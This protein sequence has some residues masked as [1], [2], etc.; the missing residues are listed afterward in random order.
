[1]VSKASDLRGTSSVSLNTILSSLFVSL[2]Q[3]EAG[4]ALFPLVHSEWFDLLHATPTQRA[5][6]LEEPFLDVLLS[7]EV[8]VLLVLI[9]SGKS[10]IGLVLRNILN[11]S[12]LSSLFQI[13]YGYPVVVQN[14][15]L[16]AQPTFIR[17]YVFVSYRSLPFVYELRTLL[18]WTID[19][20]SLRFV[21]TLLHDLYL[22]DSVYNS[23][24]EWLK[25]E[26]IYSE[27]FLT[28]CSK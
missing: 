13:Y 3:G 24:F 23:F 5:T 9:S 14:R 26:D 1:L 4:L 7:S 2:S 19:D 11:H 18:D 17:K 21:V 15:W 6:L 12:S 8:L 27:L 28:K 16:T 22:N 10:T 25:L 20:T